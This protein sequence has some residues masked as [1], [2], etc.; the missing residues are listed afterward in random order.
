MRPYTR[1]LTLIF[2]TCLLS[3]CG[4]RV[5][6]PESTEEVTS[7]QPTS[8]SESTTSA[9][10][11]IT[12]S[13]LADTKWELLKIQ[14]MDDTEWTPADP[15]RYTLTLDPDGKA[16]MRLDC[17]QGNA[18]WSSESAGQISFTPVASTSALCQDEG[19]S[20]RYANQ[21]EYVRTYVMREGHLFLATMADGAIIEFQP[22]E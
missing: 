6:N 5:D 15:S 4:E 13:E 7:D 3:A 21:F 19:L 11:D 12:S 14:S 22:V 16:Y 18:G 20:E 17:N 9:A 8:M 2:A 10:N 1:Y